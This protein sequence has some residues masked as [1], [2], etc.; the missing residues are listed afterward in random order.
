MSFPSTFSTFARPT[1]NDRLNSPSH[2]NLH[3]TV[4]SAVGQL[5]AVIGTDSS[6]LGT[7]IGDLRNPSSGGGGHVQTANKGGTGQ[8]SFNKGDLLVAQSASVLAKVSIG[9]DGQVLQADSGQSAGIKWST[10][11]ANKIGIISSVTGVSGT[12]SLTTLY[13]ASILGSTLGTSNAIR[14][15]VPISN[16]SMGLGARGVNL[17]VIYGNNLV[18]SVNTTAIFNGTLN[19]NG[20]FEGMLVADNA[21]NSQ[22]AYGTTLI[23]GIFN[24]SILSGTSYGTSSVESSATQSLIIQAQLTG[25]NTYGSIVG[26]A[27]VVEKI[28]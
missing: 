1:A 4:S 18:L 13:T 25:I 15:T 22:K 5:E 7:I 11:I 17:N 21:T 14:F 24:P 12:T 2:S 28:I 27:L 8:T 20:R 3:N 19:Y 6:I 16:F 9:S 26:Q 10:V 23:G